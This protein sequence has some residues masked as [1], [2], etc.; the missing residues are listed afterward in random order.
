VILVDN[1]QPL[2][3]LLSAISSVGFPIVLTVYLL[4]RFERK[5][6]MLT[7]TILKLSDSIN[8]QQTGG[9]NDGK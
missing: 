4:V 1:S 3:F 9:G 5:L 8:K 7:D 2:G 6:E